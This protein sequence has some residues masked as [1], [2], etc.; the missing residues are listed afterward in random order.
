MSVFLFPDNLL[1][2]GCLLVLIESMIYNG[3]YIATSHLLHSIN[4]DRE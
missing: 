1:I 3:V 2:K 4:D